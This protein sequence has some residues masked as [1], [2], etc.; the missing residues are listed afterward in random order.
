VTRRLTLPWRTL[1][2]ATVTLFT[3]AVTGVRSELL[4]E[5][6]AIVD[7]EYW[8]LL[9]GH[10]IHGSQYHLT[11]NVLAL[12]AL[13]VLFESTLGSRLWSLLLVSAAFVGGGLL[14]L[15]P[16]LPS[17][18]GLSGV[19]NGVYV[20]GALLAARA[21]LV[22]GRRSAAAVY[23]AFVAGDLLKI[24]VEAASGTPFFTDPASI[25]GV[26]LPLAHALGALGAMLWIGFARPDFDA[27]FAP[28]RR[29]VLPHRRPLTAD[30]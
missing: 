1:V 10:L 23:Y 3:A 19:L 24:V 9:S 30:S 29:R 17:Y 13:G 4:F 20:G 6:Q 15:D 25:G 27:R 16:A 5:R 14:L 26:P 12:L 22:R 8:R 2:L 18:V 11:W 21:E 7:G 28:P